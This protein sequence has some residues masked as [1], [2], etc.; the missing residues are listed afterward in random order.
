MN[1]KLIGNWLVPFSFGVYT[2]GIYVQNL[3][4]GEA[5]FVLAIWSLMDVPASSN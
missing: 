1:L 2:K 5:C 4:L 3:L